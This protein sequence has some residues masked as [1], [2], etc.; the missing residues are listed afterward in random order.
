MPKVEHS[1]HRHNAPN[2]ANL[3]ARLTVAKP[4][5]GRFPNATDLRVPRWGRQYS[6]AMSNLPAIG[7]FVW[8]IGLVVL[9][10]NTVGVIPEPPPSPT[11][12]CWAWR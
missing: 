11:S 8:S 4:L 1:D 6:S 5:A 3:M 9:V 12:T 10:V 2:R 7:A